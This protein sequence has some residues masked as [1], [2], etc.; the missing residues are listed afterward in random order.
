[1]LE[2]SRNELL[3]NVGAGTPMGELLRRYWMPIGAVTE[4]DGKETKP[5]RLMGEELVLYK[6]L[7]G[8]F[9]LVDRH[10]PHRHADLSYGFVEETGLRCNYHGWL[11]DE[12]GDC[13][14]QPYEDTV[15]PEQKLRAGCSVKAYPV[16]E[17]AGLLWAYLGPDPM[18][19]VP[20]WEPFSWQNG[21]VQIVFTEIPCNW[22]QCQENS[23]DPVHFEWMHANWT[24]RLKE[25][26][27]DYVPTH[28]EVAFEEF[29]YG[30]SY[31]R[32]REDTDKKNPLWIIGRHCL[33]PN[34]LYTGDH[35]EW[36][37]PV[38]DDTTLSVG[39]FFNR[40]PNEMEP[41][42]QESIPHWYGPLVDEETGRW[43]TSHVMNQDFV[44]W[45]GQGARSDRTQEHLGRSDRG[46]AMIRK[47]FLDDIK[48]IE[49]GDDPKA[50]VRDEK[51]NECI[52][53]P[54]IG[55]EVMINGYPKAELENLDSP[56]VRSK[57]QFIFQAGQPEHV[58]KAYEAAIGIKADKGGLTGG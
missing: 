27:S 15:D 30:I 3:M 38:D 28:L 42:V 37:V 12:K 29:E 57:R 58:T 1:M 44:A 48:A 55:S 41:Y 13:V 26:G 24:K 49:N 22:F 51:V 50:I 19:L 52:K 21:F 18:P 11:F 45:V 17:K 5:V 10:C 34:A 2:E 14:G 6:D 40:V 20:N 16:K 53:F 9:G 25:D 39:W 47:R 33:W 54:L 7:S 43:I 35:F 4:F 46:I 8:T 31:K 23:C 32:V 36:R 56:L